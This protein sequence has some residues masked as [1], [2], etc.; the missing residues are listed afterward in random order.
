MAFEM[1]EIV[2]TI[3]NP[4]EPGNSIEMRIG[5]HTGSIVAGVRGQGS[6]F[7]QHD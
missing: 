6:L 2:K 4:R 7:F 3:E 5:I 1:L